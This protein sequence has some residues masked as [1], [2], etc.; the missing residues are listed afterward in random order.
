VVPR[1]RVGIAPVAGSR[2]AVTWQVPQ[3]MLAPCA[4]T[5]DPLRFDHVLISH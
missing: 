4:L 1:Q 2:V 5:A 3:R